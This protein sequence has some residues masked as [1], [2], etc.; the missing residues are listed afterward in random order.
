[1]ST[2][3]FD[4]SVSQPHVA[5]A[6]AFV[7]T[8]VKTNLPVPFTG[9]PYDRAV[10]VLDATRTRILATAKKKGPDVVQNGF[11]RAVQR[12]D[13]ESRAPLGWIATVGGAVVGSLVYGV[14]AA[15]LGPISIGFTTAFAG[16]CATGIALLTSNFRTRKFRERIANAQLSSHDVEK[17]L[18]PY[19]AL[20]PN[21]RALAHSGVTRELSRIDA[22]LSPKAAL[23]RDRLLEKPESSADPGLIRRAA[24][25]ADLIKAI[26]KEGVNNYRL[27]DIASLVDAAEPSERK[28]LAE[29]LESQLMKGERVSVPGSVEQHRRFYDIL[30]RASRGEPVTPPASEPSKETN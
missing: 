19:T 6:T 25:F 23:T 12:W 8:P 1:M 18:A 4:L 29:T 15:A 22:S 28:H 20:P 9:N 10:T 17:M 30:M 3:A 21:E 26:R 11:D 24:E 7:P 2:P 16:A 5:P 13:R 14:N 27:H